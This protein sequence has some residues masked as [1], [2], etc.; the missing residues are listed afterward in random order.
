MMG[1]NIKDKHIE[2]MQDPEYHG[3][4][5]F[6]RPNSN[7]LTIYDPKVTLRAL[8][9]DFHNDRTNKIFSLG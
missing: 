2:M 1:K 8:F 7:P 3:P 4:G 9:R 5:L 6:S